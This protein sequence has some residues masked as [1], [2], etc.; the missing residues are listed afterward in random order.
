MD[1]TALLFTHGLPLWLSSHAASSRSTEWEPSGVGQ[2]LIILR[3]RSPMS[4]PRDKGYID[5]IYTPEVFREPHVIFSTLNPF[6]SIAHSNDNQKGNTRQYSACKTC[7]LIANLFAFERCDTPYIVTL[8]PSPLSCTSPSISLVIMDQYRASIEQRR[9]RREQLATTV[10][11]RST[12]LSTVAGKIARNAYGMRGKLSRRLSI[13]S[14]RGEVYVSAHVEVFMSENV[15]SKP[16]SS[17]LL[18]HRLV[19]SCVIFFS[20]CQS[21]PCPTL[22]VVF[23]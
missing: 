23:H 5:Y 3:Q 15:N 14:N 16:L 6:L 10:T 7:D 8:L 12:Q 1:P 11:L 20:L 18:L 4:V 22:A 19:T 13:V 2:P 21:L 9:A 17:S